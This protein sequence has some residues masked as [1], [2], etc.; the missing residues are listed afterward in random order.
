MNQKVYWRQ[1]ITTHTSQKVIRYSITGS[2][3]LYL[4]TALCS[5][6]MEKPGVN[7]PLHHLKKPV[8]TRV[9]RERPTRT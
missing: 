7:L 9:H 3:W 1:Q 8:N 4:R 5:R 6:A 2:D